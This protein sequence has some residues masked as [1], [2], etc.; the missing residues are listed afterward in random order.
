MRTDR[1]IGS[2]LLGLACCFLLAVPV[3]ADGLV[4]EG[5]PPALQAGGATQP[6]CRLHRC[7]RRQ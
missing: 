2:L 7:V 4:I 1:R 3:A 6:S 5:A